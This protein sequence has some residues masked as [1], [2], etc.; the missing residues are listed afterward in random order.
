MME[1]R[2]EL[3]QLRLR[4]ARAHVHKGTLLDA[5]VRIMA[6]LVDEMH[7][8]QY[9][10]FQ[11]MREMAREYLGDRQPTIA[12][13]KEAARRQGAIVALDP[14]GAIEALAGIVPD[15]PTRRA[16]LAAVY[17]I[18]TVSSP[19]EG[20][21]R[22]RFREVQRAL[23][24]EPGS[25]KS[26]LP[27]PDGPASGGAAPAGEIGAAGAAGGAVAGAVGAE[28]VAA[29]ATAAT[30]TGAAT[31][32]ASAEAPKRATARATKRMA[33]SKAGTESDAPLMAAKP[34]RTAAKAK[35]AAPRTATASAGSNASPAAKTARR[36]RPAASAAP[37]H[38]AGTPASRRRTTR[39]AGE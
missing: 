34:K 9:R 26:V 32:T 4:S 27:P 24:V 35:A 37:A 14:K 3:A 11:R 16:L 5:F 10:P 19:L 18:A 15:M 36:A 30:V 23:G 38:A 28:A 22:E 1:L 33:T 20:E 8:V 39:A 21:L 31:A 6:Y 2:K 25:E 12:E 7:T 29:V 17:R 13:L